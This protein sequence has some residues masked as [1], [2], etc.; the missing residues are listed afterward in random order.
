MKIRMN[1]LYGIDTITAWY[2]KNGDLFNFAPKKEFASELTKEE[3]DKV[4]EHAEWYLNQFN[5]TSMQI[6]A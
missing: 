1:G 3:A 5:A 6:M 4:M 2:R